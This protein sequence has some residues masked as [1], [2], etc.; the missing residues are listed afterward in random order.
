MGVQEQ[1]VKVQEAHQV[2]KLSREDRLKHKQAA[3]DTLQQ[4]LCAASGPHL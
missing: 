4:E 2:V 1:N 3:L